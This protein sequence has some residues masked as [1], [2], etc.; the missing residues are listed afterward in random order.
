MTSLLQK[1]W[2][3]TP[4]I[5]TPSQLEQWLLSQYKKSSFLDSFFQPRFEDLHS[6]FLL[7]DIKPA[8]ARIKTAIQTKERIMIFGDFDADGITSTVLLME[9]LSALGAQVSYRIPDRNTDSH[10]L[11]N[12]LINEIASKNVSLIITCDCGVND[13]ESLLYAQEKNIDVIVT[14]HHSPN[15]D[16]THRPA[17]SVINPLLPTCPYPESHL[18]GSAVVFK[19]LQACIEESNITPS[20]AYALIHKLLEIATIGLVAD[21]I[22]L[23]G[24][25]RSIVQLGLQALKRTQWPSIRILFERHNI[26]P[27]TITSDTIGFVIAPRLNAASRL[28]NVQTA[29]QFFLS[30]ERKSKQL[31]DELEQLN[32]DRKTLTQLLYDE[33]ISQIRPHAHCQ[34]LFEPHWQNGI[35]GLLASKHAQTLNVPVIACCMR[36]DGFLG[37]SCRAPDGYS[38]I[39]ALH[40][41]SEFL[42]SYGGHDGAAG[43]R[44]KPEHQTLFIRSLDEYFA[45]RRPKEESLDYPF[46]SP[47]LLHLQTLDTIR[48]FAPFGSGNPNPVWGITHCLIQKIYTMGEHKNHIRLLTQCKNKEVTFVGF[49]ADSFI[50]HVEEGMT[51]DILYTFNDSY[52]KEKRSLSMHIV[53]IKPHA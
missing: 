8:I 34:F 28:G 48:R 52:W 49:F 25:A 51:V 24:E 31:L 18:S 40:T 37:G 42:E 19:V 50:P 21:C 45:T 4:P 16:I 17:F 35:L 32:Q 27:E 2:H 36:H 6:P 39:E 46:L 5:E 30:D 14:D 33:S 15:P 9:G 26:D 10:G 11:K 3:P 53:D 47:D 41:T 12:H 23:V 1:L 22:P 7:G 43:F 38:I 20:D 29:V 13:V 44:M